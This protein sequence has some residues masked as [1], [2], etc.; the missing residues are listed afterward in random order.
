MNAKDET[1]HLVVVAHPRKARYSRKKSLPVESSQVDEA[2]E[3]SDD[4]PSDETEAPR[5]AAN[6]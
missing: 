6:G 2:P 4:P 5:K 3:D 1:P